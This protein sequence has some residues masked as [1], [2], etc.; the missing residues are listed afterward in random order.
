MGWG[1][2]GQ[3]GGA[4]RSHKLSCLLLVIIIWS[5]FKK[6]RGVRARTPAVFAGGGSIMGE[7]A[8]LCACAARVCVCVRARVCVFMCVCVCNEMDPDMESH[9]TKRDNQIM[10][11]TKQMAT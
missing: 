9:H 10:I 6:R 8:P 7:V 11:K 4:S 5:V 3:C 2:G 1:A